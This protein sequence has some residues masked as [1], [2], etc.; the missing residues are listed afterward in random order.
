M[1][2]PWG[3]KLKIFVAVTILCLFSLT[4]F[5]AGLDVGDINQDRRVDF[6]DFAYLATDWQEYTTRSDIT[7]DGVVNG[8]DLL[9]LAED[10]L[11]TTHPDNPE[12]TLHITGAVNGTIVV[13]LYADEAPVSVENFL[14]YAETGFYDGLIF[15]RVMKDFMVQGG[16]FDTDL[17]KKAP[18]ESIINESSN[19]LSH[20]RGTLGMARTSQPHSATSEFFINHMDNAFLDRAPIVYDGQNNAYIKYGYCV[21]GKVLSGMDVVDAIAAVDVHYVNENFETVPI[22]DVIIQSAVITRDAPVCAEK[23]EGDVNGDCSVNLADFAKLAQN[24][25]VCNSITSVC[26]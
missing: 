24:W 23:L 20:L 16:G 6:Q 3:S 11:K 25:L 4:A 1:R 18:G 2:I 10:W 26:N 7:S 19:G 13:E 9:L 14:D 5:S 8:Y 22:D 12:V 17:V 21:F 15:H